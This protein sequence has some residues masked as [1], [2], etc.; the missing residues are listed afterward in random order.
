MATSHFA[1]EA[2]I[3]NEDRTIARCLLRRGRYI[4]GHERK[5]E[6]VAADDSVSGKH[7]RLTVV[8]EDEFTIE[9]LGSVNG[10][11]VNDERIREVAPLTLESKVAL[12]NVTL[13]FERGGLPASVFRHLPEGFLRLPRYTLG[14]PIV[15]GRTSIIYDARDNILRRNVAMRVLRPASQADAGQALAFIR[16][17]Q[18]A[19]Q[20][21][22]A[23]I[24]PVH[25]F[26]LDDEIGLFCTTRFIEGE[27]LADLLSG[28][29]SGEPE[30]PHATLYSL[31][32]IFLK[33]CSTV[34][35]A[36]ARGVVHSALRPEAIIFGRFGEVFVDHWGF[37]RIGIPMHGDRPLLEAPDLGAKPPLSRYTTPEQAV[38]D[39]ELDP[40]TDVHALGAI[41]FR[42]LSLRNYNAGTTAVELL[43]HALQ[44]ALTP[45]EALTTEPPP[46]HILGGEWPERLVEICARALSPDR[47]HR[48]ANAHDLK[49]E[50]SDWIEGAATPGEH[51]RIWKQLAGLLGRH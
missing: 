29:A 42:I 13:S 3:R 14:E 8:S 16:E 35:F 6:I 47:E 30:A 51:T 45:A 50:L 26:G 31:L 43:D 32:Q 17:A 34:A 36:H 11:T 15:E 18:I 1:L 49:K 27:S 33:A 48:F 40:R 20:L 38:G 22:H 46:A 2:V 23:G 28:M 25:D 37:A 21:S 19:S 5:N 39:D 24:L 4:I 10:T 41:L 12:G 9:D 44:P 7:A